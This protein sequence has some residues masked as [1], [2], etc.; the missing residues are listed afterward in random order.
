MSPAVVELILGVLDLLERVLAKHATPT[1]APDH[2]GVT[3]AQIDD[4]IRKAKDLK[5]Q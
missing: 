5:P 3:D 1:P 2:D 4:L